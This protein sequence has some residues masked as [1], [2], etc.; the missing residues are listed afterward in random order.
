MQDAFALH[1]SAIQVFLALQLGLHVRQMPFAFMQVFI[2]SIGGTLVQAVI[3]EQLQKT[4]LLF[5]T[6]QSILEFFDPEKFLQLQKGQNSW[7]QNNTQQ[8]R[9]FVK[10]ARYGGTM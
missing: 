8:S 10:A 9:H 2:L 6:P 5:D 4:P 1:Y 3:K 7:I